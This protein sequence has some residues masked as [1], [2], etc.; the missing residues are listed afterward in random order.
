VEISEGV[1]LIGAYLAREQPLINRG[2]L[3]MNCLGILKHEF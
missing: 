2:V 1:M 3:I